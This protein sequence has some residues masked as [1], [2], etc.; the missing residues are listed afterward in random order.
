MKSPKLLALSIIVSASLPAFSATCQTGQAALT[1]WTGDAPG[2]CRHIQNSDI[3]A[4]P[5]G[6]DPEKSVAKPI[7][8]VPV[9]DKALPKVPEGF[10]VEVFATGLKTPRTLRAAPN[11]DLFLS[12]VGTGR[13]LV[14]KAGQPNATPDV[15]AEGLDR[16][17]GIVFY[18]AKNPQYVY[19]AASNQVVRYPYK[20][21][22]VKASAPAKV[23][24]A[25]I[26]NSRH[27]T[28][29]LAITA[30]GKRL[31]VAVGSSSNVAG[32]MPDKTPEE[33]KAHEKTHGRGAAWGEEMDR[34]VVR[35]FDPEGK[36]VRNY[37][38]GLRNCS[39][40]AMQPKT[41]DIWCTVIER[42]H[43]GPD[44]VPDMFVRVREGDFH[45]WP[46]FYLN[47]VEDPA[48]LGKRP[49][50]K[51]H[52]RA[53]ETMILSHSSPLAVSFYNGKAFPAEYRGDAFITLHGS[54][55]KPNRAGYKVIRAVMKNGKAT[56]EYIDFMT[57][58][59]VDND[60]ASGRPA[61]IVSM[62]D[63]SLLVSEDANG[64]VY[65][66]KHK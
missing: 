12:E 27:W 48:W 5:Q 7:T 44:L 50:L 34:A 29:D 21:G 49:D 46:W 45:G 58:F 11:G 19:V 8:I 61:G 38:T 55:S 66:V 6:T 59:M 52:V 54:H 20:K 15:F 17:Y 30:D 40:L 57:G 56:G 9:P 60:H 36:S 31:L 18:P 64:V 1:D 62:P 42:D 63:G 53:P 43:V 32:G 41:N 16:P 51:A 24:V 4:P 14:Y 33:I 3:P 23:I 65:R 47:G 28:R 13:V 37:A 2:V 26:S 25:N 39:G 10:N 22:D 35:V